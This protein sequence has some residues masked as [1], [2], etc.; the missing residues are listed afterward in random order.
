[1]PDFDQVFELLEDPNAANLQEI[2]ALI[3]LSPII[4]SQ[5]LMIPEFLLE[6]SKIMLDENIS[7]Y[8]ESVIF[9]T[10]LEIVRELI[11]IE[12]QNE[13]PKINTLVNKRNCILIVKHSVDFIGVL[14]DLLS[15]IVAKE[16]FNLYFSNVELI[17]DIVENIMTIIGGESYKLFNKLESLCN[18]EIAINKKDCLML[19]L[20][21]IL[22]NVSSITYT[23]LLSSLEFDLLNLLVNIQSLGAKFD[24]YS[25]IIT[26]KIEQ[27]D[28]IVVNNIQRVLSNQII[29]NK[30]KIFIYIC[31]NLNAGLDSAVLG[32]DQRY[33][34]FSSEYSKSSIQLSV[35]LDLKK[36][37]VLPDI[38]KSNSLPNIFKR[39]L[40]P[41]FDSKILET[42]YHILITILDIV[43]E[44][45]L[46]DR[47]KRC[48]SALSFSIQKDLI[49]ITK[50]DS[51]PIDS[52]SKYLESTDTTRLV[53]LFEYLQNSLVDDWIC[54]KPIVHQLTKIFSKFK[55]E[56]VIQI[57]LKSNKLEPLTETVFLTPKPPL[58]PP[59]NNPR[60]KLTTMY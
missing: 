60:H 57:P 41:D 24:G 34:R 59:T 55:R 53:E 43:E 48:N 32:K 4:H 39:P 11:S 19:I 51:N 47:L 21:H 31:D 14:G 12:K 26:S 16:D 56:Q 9:N 28:K 46:S 45:T 6:L 18:Q 52:A 50:D 36:L 49:S 3:K 33:L 22:E 58:A 17:M 27:S 42:I 2:I 1:M 30:S 8:D 37:T 40:T 20:E 29:K 25:K 15:Y 5:I 54:L 7:I 38:G 44:C 35:N 13:D 10:V 23:T